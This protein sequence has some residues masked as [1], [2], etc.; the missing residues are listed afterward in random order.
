[1]RTV[2]PI[3]SLLLAACAAAPKVKPPEVNVKVP[4]GWSTGQAG[5]APADTLWWHTFK[6]ENLKGLVAEALER[7]HNL[8]A[9][10]AR[11]RAAAARA[12][13]A[14]APLYPD[15]G[16]RAG[17]SRR[18]QNFIGLPIPGSGNGVLTSTSSSF[19]LS[20]DVSWELDL[21]NRL[22]AGA[23]A[24]LADVQAARADHRGA[25]LSLAGQTVKTW[26][27]AVEARRQVDL[28]EATVENLKT[29]SEVVRE[30]YRRGLRHA[31][32]LRRALSDLAGS[33]AVLQQRRLILDG[34]RRQL[35]VLLGRYPA[36]ALSPGMNLPKLPEAIPAGLPADLVSR[37]PDLMAAERRLAASN[38]RYT[39]ARRALYPRISLTGSAGT[40]SRDLENLL[41]GDFSVW[42]LAGNILQPLFQGGRIRGGI[43]L[44]AS[45]S[46]QAVSAYVQSV[47]SA[48]AEV[49]TALAAESLL[50]KRQEALET[51]TEQALAAR[52]LAED[53]YAGGLVDLNTMLDA[54]R[55][56]Y[57]S[58][59]QLI[60][61]RR[62]R[63][64]NRVNL[65]LALGGGF[66]R[67]DG[68]ALATSTTQTEGL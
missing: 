23:S 46:E 6:D 61:V 33:E 66:E 5:V 31:L 35:E 24:A 30:R 52:R 67:T 34:T 40:S 44:A 48:Y 42:N 58:E 12:R 1:M 65:H 37:R 13:I 9:S 32:D 15:A 59:S 27:A 63:L 3:L 55:G 41:D 38:A 17:A 19:G 51:A 62:Q 10:A 26:F 57:A 60:A 28:S 14:G 45:Q 21:W 8:Q 22:G 18:K 4:A 39:Q 20:L 7:N 11:V 54:Q 43:Q 36:A 29:S 53:R 16:G 25:R 64:E 50:A 2:L 47:L 49:E 68:M 56:A